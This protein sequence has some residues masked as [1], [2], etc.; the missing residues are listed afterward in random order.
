[1][2]QF[3]QAKDLLH[4]FMDGMT[5]E[6]EEQ[7]LSDFML[8]SD[9]VPEEWEEYR[10]MFRSFTTDAYAFSDAELESMTNESDAA[11]VAVSHSAARHTLFIYRAAAC[12]AFLLASA[13]VTLWFADYSGTERDTA[14]GHTV[15][16][17]KCSTTATG[18]KTLAEKT[19]GTQTRVTE[20]Q[21][22]NATA[23]K[24]PRDEAACTSPT[25][26][27]NEQTTTHTDS[28]P[29][30]FPPTEDSCEMPG[31]HTVM[32]D[33]SSESDTPFRLQ[34][35]DD[36]TSPALYAPAIET[37]TGMKNDDSD[38]PSL[39]Q[40]STFD[41]PSITINDVPGF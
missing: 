23:V 14:I 34:E 26:T 39:A 11:S 9:E 13:A 7:E 35:E 8:L 29:T 27:S 15:L 5:T 12:T 37:K 1:M 21:S 33:I 16:T 41:I 38:T 22:T 40:A 20:H 18:V 6:E 36:S 10:E 3:S 19:G 25:I 32:A 31:F 17:A 24:T 4:R 2:I 28:A 30:L